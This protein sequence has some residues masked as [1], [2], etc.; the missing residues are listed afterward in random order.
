MGVPLYWVEHERERSLAIV[1]RPRGGDWLDDEMAVLRRDGVDVLV[2]LLTPQEQMELGL[3]LERSAC[4]QAGIEYLNFPVSDRGVPESRAEFRSFLEQLR[5]EWEKGKRIGAHCRMG[6]GR[7]SLLIA[8]L[9]CSHGL[10]AREA[11][12]RLSVA[13][14]L[15]V[16][17]TPEQVA[18]VDDLR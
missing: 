16:P 18:W 10:S 15:S 13:R 7:S 1:P 14:G 17:D 5:T 8:A 9:L 12:A 6:I 4:E 2:S 11:F 3:E